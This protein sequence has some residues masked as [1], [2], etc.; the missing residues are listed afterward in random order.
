MLNNTFSA[1]HQVS[2]IC[3]KIF[4]A[5]NTL[6]CSNVSMPRHIKMQLVKSLIIP[7]ISYCS[8]LFTDMHS[9][10]FTRLNVAFNSCI[11]FIFDLFRRAHV[12][13]FAKT[14]LGCSLKSYLD[15]RLIIAVRKMVISAGPTYLKTLFRFTLSRRMPNM[16]LPRI[17][18]DAMNRSVTVTAARKWNKLPI[19][20]K[21]N[22]LSPHFAKLCFDF[23]CNPP[24]RP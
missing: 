2:S 19:H 6:K 15:Y 16:L 3:G 23:Y 10:L 8:I 18:S 7:H 11:R 1:S 12:S 14:L 5:L 9:T 13:P 22:I 4:G 21:R 17:C 20:I 24:E